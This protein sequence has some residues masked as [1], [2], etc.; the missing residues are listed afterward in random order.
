MPVL[1]LPAQSLEI[2][3]VIA[4]AG[5]V[6][7]RQQTPTLAILADLEERIRTFVPRDFY[8]IALPVTT[9]TGGRRRRDTARVPLRPRC[10][11]SYCRHRASR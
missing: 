4:L 11:S 2:G 3:G 5:I 8:K 6:L 10:Q 9:E 1:V 7:T